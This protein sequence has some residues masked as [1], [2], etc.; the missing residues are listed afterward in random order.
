[1]RYCLRFC[2]I[3]DWRSLGLCFLHYYFPLVWNYL[4]QYYFP[5]NWEYYL[6]HYF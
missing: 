1:M 4:V 6:V 5:L 3:D 2:W